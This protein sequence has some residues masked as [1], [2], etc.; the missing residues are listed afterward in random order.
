MSARVYLSKALLILSPI[1]GHALLE[2]M[3]LCSKIMNITYLDVSI[4]EKNVLQNFQ[5]DQVRHVKNL[6]F[7]K[8]IK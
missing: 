8:I 7:L 6:L 4:V 5:N 2:I 1:L 3:A